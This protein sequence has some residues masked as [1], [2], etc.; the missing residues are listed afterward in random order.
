MEISCIAVEDEPLALE[1]L[2]QFIDDTP[3]LELKAKF[4][5]SMEALSYLQRNEVQLMFLDIQMD[6]LTGLQ[7]LDLLASKPR[8]IITTAYSEYALR[9]YEYGIAD[10]LLKPYSFERFLQAVQKVKTD[11][12][13]VLL[14]PASSFIFI[15]VDY[16]ILKVDYDQ[17]LYIEGMRDYRCIVLPTGKLLTSTTFAELEATLPKQMFAR[18]HKSFIV[19]LQKIKSIERHRVYIQDKILPIGETY[20]YEFYQMINKAL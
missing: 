4:T 19:S 9:G 15:K 14:S 5:N 3:W 8:V 13:P 7:M 18:I 10:Y 17:I 6:C 1:K 12:L 2:V 20:K 11:V 16:R